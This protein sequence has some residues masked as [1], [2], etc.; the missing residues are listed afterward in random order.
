MPRSRKPRCDG[1][2]YPR[3][4]TVPTM[5]GFGADFSDIVQP[6]R[7]GLE[8]SASFNNDGWDNEEPARNLGLERWQD[9]TFPRF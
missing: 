2:R 6:I 5:V 3:R 1:Y 9:R 4:E 7:E 8:R